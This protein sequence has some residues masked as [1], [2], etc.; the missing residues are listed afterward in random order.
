MKAQQGLRRIRELSRPLEPLPTG[1]EPM[2]RVFRGI[3]AVLFDVYG[4]LFVSAAGGSTPDAESAGPCTG[5]LAEAFEALQ[6]PNPVGAARSAERVL[7][8]IT[9]ERHDQARAAGVDFPEVE[10][11]SVFQELLRRLSSPTRARLPSDHGTAELLALE[12]E[13]RRNPTW[14]MPAAGAT[15]AALKDRG[16]LLGIVSNAQFYT[17]WLF[18][19]HLGANL[20]TLG[21]VPALCAWSYRC[22]C[23]KPSP[24]LFLPPLRELQRR[25]VPPAATLVVG[26]DRR[27]D[28]DPA[29]GLGCRTALFAGDARSYRPRGH[30]P[31]PDDPRADLLLTALPQLLEI[32]P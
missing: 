25:G 32:V 5:F 12:Y 6:L 30:D 15:L 17:P 7:E 10:I 19:A 2:L 22:G 27:N 24:S 18:P 11:V 23:A 21:F 14:P 26:N 16:L 20:G 31:A 9:R 8:T 28:V 29:S 1:V 13:L 3:R 4:T